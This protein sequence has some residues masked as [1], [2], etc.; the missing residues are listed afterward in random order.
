MLYNPIFDI[1]LSNFDCYR[2]PE[3]IPI[4]DDVDPNK[5][6]IVVVTYKIHMVS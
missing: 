4:P 2:V 5:V 1:P 6:I 3:I